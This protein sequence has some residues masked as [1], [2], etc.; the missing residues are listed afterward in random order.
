M[1]EQE[2]KNPVGNPDTTENKNPVENPNQPTEQYLQELEDSYRDREYEEIDYDPN[3]YD[4]DYKPT[5]DDH[6]Q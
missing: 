5:P 2:N 6:Y 3:E 1:S 4:P